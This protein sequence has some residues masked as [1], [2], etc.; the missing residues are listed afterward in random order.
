ME[1]GSTLCSNDSP[2]RSEE[3]WILCHGKGME[4][5]LFFLIESK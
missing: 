2:S 5:L 4:A 3:E 1:K